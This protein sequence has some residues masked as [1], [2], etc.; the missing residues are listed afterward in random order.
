MKKPWSGPENYGL[1]LS[2]PQPFPVI[3]FNTGASW[4]TKRWTTA[5]FAAVADSLLEQGFGIAFFGGAMDEENVREILSRMQ[6]G[7]HSRIATFTGRVTLLELAALIQKCAVFL[8]NDSGPMHVAV[9]QKAKVVAVFGSSN[10]MGFGPYDKSAVVVTAP[11][12]ACRPCGRHHCDHHS[13]MKE[14]RPESVL[15]HVLT[16]AG[17]LSLIPRPAV[18]FDRD[19]VLNIDKEYLYR[20]ED[21]EWLPGAVDVIRLFNNKGYYTFVVSNQSGVARGL[22]QEQDVRALHS[23]I[24]AE[25]A[26]EAAHI[27]AFYYCP[28]HASEGRA[29]Y[30]E[31]C[32]CRKPKPGMILQALAEWPVDREKS[33]LIGD[34]ASDIQAAQAA[35]IKGLLFDADHVN[36]LEF[37]RTRLLAE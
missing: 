2:A 27:D 17:E 20:N 34:K 8:T 12:V 22:Y 5:G 31:D 30:R 29:P 11:A 21:F 15:Q 19:G 14:I 13:C 25:L 18:F 37:I 26:K 33:L 23:W 36:L 9:A 4:P 7:G 6:H 35:G 16:M 28:H 1:P 10:E 32:Q 24:N 3:G